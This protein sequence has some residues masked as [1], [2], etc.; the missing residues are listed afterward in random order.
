M[1]YITVSYGASQEQIFNP[2]CR[3]S[4]LLK[5]IR[6]RCKCDTE[7]IELSDESGNI[8]NLRDP[9]FAQRYASELLDERERLVLLKVEQNQSDTGL[10][11]YIPMLE[12][13]DRLL[14]GDFLARLAVKGSDRRAKSNTRRRDKPSV[15]SEQKETSRQNSRERSSDRQKTAKSDKRHSARSKR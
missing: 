12:S 13:G 7:D 8:K 10:I 4:L 1:V 15:S 2:N 9:G 11:S 14:N 5:N 6:H 3:T